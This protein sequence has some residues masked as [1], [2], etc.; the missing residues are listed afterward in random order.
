[1]QP[2]VLCIY[3]LEMYSKT[4]L[5]R[6]AS[7]LLFL[8]LRV[9]MSWTMEERRSNTACGYPSLLTKDLIASMWASASEKSVIPPVGKD[10]EGWMLNGFV[11]LVE[12]SGSLCLFDGPA[13]QCQ[14]SND[15]YIDSLLPASVRKKMI[16]LSML[17]SAISERL[18]QFHSHN[19]YVL[20]LL[21]YDMYCTLRQCMTDYS[22]SV[23]PQNVKLTLSV[24]VT[25]NPRRPP[26]AFN[27]RRLYSY[28]LSIYERLRVSVKLQTIA[29][30]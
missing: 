26:V 3:N 28:W 15:A 10:C 8:D 12:W 18:L 1:M 5:W 14:Q 30:K 11:L 23:C 13:V 24:K 25:T 29:E 2:Q 17:L 6:V 9:L 4:N 27:A 19:G 16:W 20:Y 22:L 7:F 21:L